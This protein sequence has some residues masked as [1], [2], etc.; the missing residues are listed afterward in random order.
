[1]KADYYLVPG[2]IASGGNQTSS[3]GRFLE[4]FREADFITFNYDSF[5]EAALLRLGRWIPT[6]GFGLPVFA[7]RINPLADGAEIPSA[8]ESLVLHIHGSLCV[9]ESHFSFSG[10]DKSG[11]RWLKQKPETEFLF[12]PDSLGL[13]FVPWQ[14]VIQPLLG[15]DRLE[16][17]VIAPVPEKTEGLKR[18]FVMKVRERA[19]TVV[20]TADVVIAVGY[21]F[22]PV[23]E[24]SFGF[25]LRAIAAKQDP[26]L[27][28]VSPSA[29]AT[30]E[31]LAKTY[32][33]VTFKSVPST[34]RQWASTSF[35]LP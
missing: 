30:I 33:D 5:I 22:N 2:L 12:D 6:D 14:R 20:S 24:E 35:A 13:L 27:I 15:A 34:F 4:R 10:P 23:D 29:E 7:A 9:Y 19:S 18:E 16:D 28:V 1:M 8:S 31:R 17:R 11:V 26:T 3:Y 32:G 25:L 21:S